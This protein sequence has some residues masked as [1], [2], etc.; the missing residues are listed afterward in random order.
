MTGLDTSPL[1][2]LANLAITTFA[3]VATAAIPIIGY[4]VITWLR[5]HAAQVNQQA[6]MAASSQADSII[7]K[8]FAYAAQMGR[9][10]VSTAVSYSV[11]QAPNLFKRLGF[12]TSTD[13][14]ISA[15]TRMVQ[16]RLVP[17]V[18]PA[19]TVDV[20]LTAGK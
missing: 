18:A 4:F 8:G 20:N 11:K 3:S 15:V 16:A 6:Q 12:D 9:D 7:Q 14:G 19:S 2:P 13:A 17:T 5:A 1:I 10:P